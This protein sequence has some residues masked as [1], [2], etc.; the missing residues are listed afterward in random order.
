MRAEREQIS[1]PG[2]QSIHRSDDRDGKDLI[3]IRI[4][5]HARNLNGRHYLGYRLELGSHSGST[6]ARPATGLHKNGLELTEDRGTDDQRVI[7]TEDFV[8]ETS[9]ASTKVERRHQYIGVENDPHSA[10]WL[11]ARAASARFHGGDDGVFSQ[12]TG[13]RPFFS[14][15]KELIPSS[16]SF[17]VLAERFAQEFAAGP[18]LLVGQA[19]DLDRELW[20]QGDR[21]RPSRAHEQNDNTK[22]YPLGRQT[23]QT[24]GW[25]SG[26]PIG[27]CPSLDRQLDHRSDLIP[28]GSAHLPAESRAR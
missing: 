10:C 12:G 9:R 28:H 4:P 3:V 16:A 14:I 23:D 15:C 19:V 25:Q 24:P 1:V 21:H 18:A 17:S 22:S 11:A 26:R 7:T 13:T 8:E 5:A 6:I 27:I 2:N 20:R